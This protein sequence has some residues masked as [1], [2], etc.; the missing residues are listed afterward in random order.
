[1][2]EAG[3][4]SEECVVV[5]KIQTN[6]VGRCNRKWV[7]EE[8]NLFASILKKPP[9]QDLGQLSLTA[10]C[11]VREALLGCISSVVGAEYT[12]DHDQQLKLH[13]PNDVYYA[14][15]KISGILM[16]KVDG[17]LIVSIGVNVNA[18]PH[19]VGSATSLKAVLWGEATTK[20]I[21][22]IDLLNRVLKS[23]GQWFHS[24]HSLGFSRARNYW[25]RNINEIM[26]RVVIKNGNWSVDGVFQD[27]DDCGRLVLEKNGNR[28]FI[29]SGDLFANQEGLVI[30]HA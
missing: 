20:S 22:T 29:S 23:I 24:L 10:A 25:L 14:N 28:L 26:C 7:S 17:W 5:A 11:A 9:V 16:T 27:I 4:V 8:G 21:D 19:N 30:N 3:S 15:S 12:A 13:W 2:V 18:R 6:G 1:M